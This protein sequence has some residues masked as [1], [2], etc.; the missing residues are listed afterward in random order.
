MKTSRLFSINVSLYLAAI[1]LV[2]MAMF[3]PYVLTG[4]TLSSEKVFTVIAIIA[5]VNVVTAIFVP[6]SIT[7]I[8]EN[9]VSLRRIEVSFFSVFFLTF[10]TL[11][12]LTL[13][14]LTLPYL[15]LPY[16]T[17]P[18][19]TLPYHSVSRVTLTYSFFIF[20]VKTVER[21]TKELK[22]SR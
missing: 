4:N 2:T 18:H 16:L 14:Y 22:E 6:K 13:P 10:I 3:V 7:A 19:L 21:E 17:L 5:S 8:K 12:Y 11:P 9:S 20:R 1:P 15:T